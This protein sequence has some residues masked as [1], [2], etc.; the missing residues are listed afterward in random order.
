MLT[1]VA[2]GDLRCMRKGCSGW[3]N[4]RHNQLLPPATEETV[5]NFPIEEKRRKKK[6]LP[7]ITT[8]A[9]MPTVE[10][11]PF[12]LSGGAQVMQRP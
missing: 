8:A 1:K 9:L 4:G 10:N 2:V 3:T 12:T 5:L 6:V 7:A 11:L